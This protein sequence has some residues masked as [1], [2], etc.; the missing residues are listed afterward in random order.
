MMSESSCMV[1]PKGVKHT[2]A[3]CNVDDVKLLEDGYCTVNLDGYHRHRNGEM[4]RNYDRLKEAT[5]PLRMHYVLP[6]D[7]KPIPQ[8]KRQC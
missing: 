4:L 7:W 2:A 3:V 8:L 6:A 5:E 1:D